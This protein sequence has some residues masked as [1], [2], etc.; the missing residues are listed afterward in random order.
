MIWCRLAPI[1]VLCL[2]PPLAHAQVPP[3][4]SSLQKIMRWMDSNKRFLF[5]G[6][7]LAAAALADGYMTRRCL[8]AQSCRETNPIFGSHPS[9]RRL[10]LEGGGF[11]AGEETALYFLNRWTK[12]SPDR[13]ES[14]TALFGAAVPIALHAWAAYHNALLSLRPPRRVLACRKGSCKS[15]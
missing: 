12:D 6:T 11:I 5:A 3:H 9:A 13:F 8:V 10:W 14:N 7:A 1:L 4:R 15:Q 2:F